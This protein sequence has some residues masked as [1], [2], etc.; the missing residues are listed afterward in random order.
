MISRYTTFVGAAA[1]ARTGD[2]LSAPALLL[3][4]LA[5]TGSPAV[6]A[7]LVG[8]LTIAA[9]A[10]GPLLGVAIDRSE[11]PGRLL[12]LAL[13]GYA[14]GLTAIGLGL[15][16]LPDAVLVGVAAVT[17]LLNPAIAGGW[18]AQLPLVRGRVP[19]E[20]ASAVDG[21]TFT[22]ASLIGP[23]LAGL[24]GAPVGIVLAVALVAAA[25]PVALA[26]PARAAR[27]GRVPLTRGFAVIV[28]N[29]ALRRATATSVVS[30][31]GFGAALVCFPLLGAQRLG[32]AEYGAL[33][34][35]VLA[36]G[37]L[38]ANLVLA[39]FPPPLRPD[40]VVTLST[41]GLAAALGLAA[42]AGPAGLVVAAVLAG[43]SEGPQLTA[44]L[45]V[46]HR[47]APDAVRAQVFTTGASLKIGGFG[48][49]SALAGPVAAAS[50]TT[51]LMLAAGVQ[52]LALGAG[53]L[54]KP[55]PERVA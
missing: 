25:V 8:A 48:V 28:T 10:G 15:G 3:A 6:G 19:L 43:V 39:R 50:T 11:R 38:L 30:Y 16:R 35:S 52:L 53:V 9:A 31:V 32:G 54:R 2:E 51:A 37:A 14:A 21:L 49:G 23:A 55:S 47:E 18:T 45:A 12:A 5:L 41:A 36:A 7:A 13:A 27:P 34:L 33:L 29:P 26:L 20:R 42:V 1:V 4:G 17:G 24:A 44:L 22:A 46:R 40:T